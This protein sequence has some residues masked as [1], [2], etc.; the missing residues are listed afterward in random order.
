MVPCITYG[1][2]N[3]FDEGQHIVRAVVLPLK[4]VQGIVQPVSFGNARTNIGNVTPSQKRTNLPARQAAARLSN[5][6]AKGL[7]RAV[8]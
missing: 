5:N 4:R 3:R 2:H 6:V 7:E 8:V 1:V